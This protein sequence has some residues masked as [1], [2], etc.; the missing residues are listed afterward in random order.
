[1][2]ELQKEEITDELAEIILDKI[3]LA[4]TKENPYWQDTVMNEKEGGEELYLLQESSL[5]KVFRCSNKSLS[6]DAK[7]ALLK[8]FNN[9]G[10]LDLVEI[11]K[12]TDLENQE[13][14]DFLLQKSSLLEENAIVVK[15]ENEKGSYRNGFDLNGKSWKG[16]LFFDYGYIQKSNVDEIIGVF[17][18]P[19]KI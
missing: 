9:L 11:L 6:Q 16:K 15:I 14:N 2:K 1:M 3:H 10:A 8:K 13:S 12:N 18:G 19:E 5:K 17:L 7:E 4:M